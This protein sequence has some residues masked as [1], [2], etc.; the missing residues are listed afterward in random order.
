MSRYFF[1]KIK[2]LTKENYLIKFNQCNVNYN[3][4]LRR[5]SQQS[6]VIK[7]IEFSGV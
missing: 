3:Y 1:V 5:A 4:H 6:E 2:K 7:Q